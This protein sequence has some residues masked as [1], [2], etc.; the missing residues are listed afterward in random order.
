MPCIAGFLTEFTQALELLFQLT[1]LADATG[2]MADVFVEQFIHGAAVGR[3]RILELQQHSDLVECHVQAA[4][5]PNEAQPF[6][7]RDPID[8]VVAVGA[9]SFRQQ[10]LSL[11]IADGLHLC[12][13]MA[14]KF[15]DFHGDGVPHSPAWKVSDLCID[16]SLLTL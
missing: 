16:C 14:G 4:A 8:A 9:G 5:V 7:M 12:A 15:P 10:A 3:G 11:L 1:Q 2:D 13:G 6:R